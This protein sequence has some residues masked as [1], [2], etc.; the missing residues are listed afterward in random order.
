MVAD[1]TFNSEKTQWCTTKRSQYTGI[2]LL[3]TGTAV[4]N[5]SL[6]SVLSSWPIVGNIFRMSALWSN[7][8]PTLSVLD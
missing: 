8:P 6:L 1:I 4:S 5:Y 7:P 2:G 3:F